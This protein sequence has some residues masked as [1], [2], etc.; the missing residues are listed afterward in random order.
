MSHDAAA[1]QIR[2]LHTASQQLR[3]SAPPSSY[4]RDPHDHLPVGAG[5]EACFAGPDLTQD[6]QDGVAAVVVED[7]PEPPNAPIPP[8]AAAQAV[9]I[10]ARATRRRLTARAN[11]LPQV[12]GLFIVQYLPLLIDSLP[13]LKDPVDR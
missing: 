4:S 3:A 1:A 2:S 10:G 11:R 8:A 13:A 12:F 9:R 7:S 5:G 6:V